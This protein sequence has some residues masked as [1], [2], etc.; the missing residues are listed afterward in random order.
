MEVGVGVLSEDEKIPKG[1]PDLGGVVIMAMRR[2]RR[3][4]EA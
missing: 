2:R 3:H 4:V 1:C